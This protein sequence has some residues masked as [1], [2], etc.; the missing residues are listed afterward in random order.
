MSYGL[1][2][3]VKIAVIFG[4]IIL[5]FGLLTTFIG[6]QKTYNANMC[7]GTYIRLL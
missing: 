1:N 5:G 4:G 3:T 6:V 7:I 2:D